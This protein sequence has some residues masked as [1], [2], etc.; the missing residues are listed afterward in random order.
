MDSEIPKPGNPGHCHPCWEKQETEK[1]EKQA[2]ERAVGPVLHIRLG[3][4]LLGAVCLWALV[5]WL[6]HLCAD[7]IGA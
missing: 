1:A 5:M 6:F 2:A 7:L 4:V 3:A